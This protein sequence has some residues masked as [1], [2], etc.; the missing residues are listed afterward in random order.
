MLRIPIAFFEGKK[1][2]R[3][4]LSVQANPQK[5]SSLMRA[6]Y[7]L[8]GWCFDL[9]SS[10][11]LQAYREL[12]SLTDDQNLTCL[13]HLEV[14]EGASLFGKPLHQFESKIAATLRKI[15][16]LP[17]SIRN[18]PSP[19][20][21][22][23]VLTQKEIDRISFDPPRFGRALSLLNPE[24]SPFLLVGDRYGEW[25]LALGRIDLLKEMMAMVRDKGF[26]PILSGQWATFFLP[27]AKPLDAAAF[28]VP[29]NKKWGLF[30]LS[31]ASDLIKK[32]DRPVIGLNPLADGELLKTS[33]EAF[34]FLFNELKIHSAIARFSSEEEARAIL[35]AL[36]KFPS[37]ILRRRP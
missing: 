10:K 2:P 35:M 5:I 28:A 24:E 16:S 30:S 34:S 27:T 21:F 3:I 1:I 23:E 19:A 12:R 17:P 37:L 13:C 7:D 6:A 4:I 20:P 11:H 8:G 33:E 31:G 36:E 9:P 22:S 32:F 15:L 29:I 25:L 18:F 14:E 26:I